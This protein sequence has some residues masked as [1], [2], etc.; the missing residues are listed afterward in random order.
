MEKAALIAADIQLDYFR[1]FN[2]LNA[3]EKQPKDYVTEADKKSEKKII[4]ILTEEFPDYGFIG[5]ESGETNPE[6]K[7]KFVIDPLDGT[8]NFMKGSSF[9]CISIAL[10][11]LSDGAELRSIEQ[12]KAGLIYAPYLKEMF[13]AERGSGAYIDNELVVRTE[14]KNPGVLNSIG[15]KQLDRR[16]Q[17]PLID[18]IVQSSSHRRF[19]GAAAL[20]LAYVA[21]GRF[22][23]FAHLCLNPWD[24]A[25]AAV[26]L[27]EA[28]CKVSDLNGGRDIFYNKNI[29]ATY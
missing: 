25:A 11:D 15:F 23:S 14:E 10:A 17:F 28:N 16:G 26:I 24:M 1:D 19:L 4:E 12:I 13:Y 29:L 20:E 8:V 5:E 21:A 2:K 7:M 3:E 18:G 9:F 22:D 6:A 27:E